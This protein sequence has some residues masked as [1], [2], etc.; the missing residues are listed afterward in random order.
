[1]TTPNVTESQIRM[2]E[3]NSGMNRGQIEQ[4]YRAFM[5]DYPDGSI[6]RSE[7]VAVFRRIYPNGNPDK[8]AQIAFKAFDMNKSGKITFDEFLLATSFVINGRGDRTK[9]WE[10]AFDIYDVN[11][12][13][14]INKSEMLN[15]LEALYELDGQ[16]RQAAK[17]KVEEIFSKYDVNLDGF[18]CKAEFINYMSTD[19]SAIRT[20]G[21]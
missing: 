19:P 7:F 1:M 3:N 16:P 4:W 15:I 12:N 5:Q 6:D 8:Y 14:K 10:F 11:N 13:G 9:A 2:L 21:V 18:L 17:E 20:L